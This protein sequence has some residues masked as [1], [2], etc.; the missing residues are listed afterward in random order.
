MGNALVKLQ[1]LALYAASDLAA[2]RQIEWI[3]KV[4][5]S[6]KLRVLDLKHRDV[7]D[8]IAFAED[9]DML[10]SSGLAIDYK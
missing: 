8:A 10:F 9:A 4:K 1:G 3:A 2:Y 5:E 6:G 7:R